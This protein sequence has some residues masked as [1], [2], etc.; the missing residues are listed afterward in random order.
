[1]EVKAPQK[2]RSTSM[3]L[4]DYLALYG[5]PTSFEILKNVTPVKNGEMQILRA[6]FMNQFGAGEIAIFLAKSFVADQKSFVAA[7]K[8]GRLGV[9]ID[10]NENG[11]F[12]DRKTIFEMKK[13]AVKK[14]DFSS[15]LKEDD[16]DEE[17]EDAEEES[18]FLPA[19]KSA[20]KKK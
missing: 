2:K 10:L 1:M 7:Y 5:V 9:V 17:D 13:E 8:A 12:S 4:K 16:E 15:F 11:T 14:V 18:A 19:A 6:H 20:K 3:P